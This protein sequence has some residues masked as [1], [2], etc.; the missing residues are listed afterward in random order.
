[1]AGVIEQINIVTTKNKSLGSG[2]GGDVYL[3][4]DGEFA[5]K[6]I[7]TEQEA[8]TGFVSFIKKNK[9]EEGDDLSEFHDTGVNFVREF[10]LPITLNHPNVMKQYGIFE[11]KGGDGKISFG[12]KLELADIGLDKILYSGTKERLS[13]EEKRSLSCQLFNAI[14]YLGQIG[15]V[16]RDIKPSNMMITKT[17]VLKIS[18]FGALCPSYEFGER[19]YY[20]NNDGGT[21]NYKPPEF[22][23]G[24]NN[25][26]Y[27]NGFDIWSAGVT[28]IEIYTSFPR[29]SN[30]GFIDNGGVAS[31]QARK[32]LEQVM[33]CFP[34]AERQ[35][36]YGANEGP[37]DFPWF[38]N[39]RAKIAY[40]GG[41]NLEDRF[42]QLML[43]NWGGDYDE[44][45][46]D[47][48]VNKV[49]KFEAVERTSEYFDHEFMN[50]YRNR[51]SDAEV[52]VNIN[53]TWDVIDLM[54]IPLK[55]H[56]DNDAYDSDD[57]D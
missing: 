1:M 2:A 56:S 43:N 40:L 55:Q 18:D 29:F 15:L 9:L 45:M 4:E 16:H 46:A 31:K 3:S 32:V 48:L 33:T 53:K 38:K 50:G 44:T 28:M 47:F 11:S 5:L 13:L 6:V 23:I 25:Y 42:R 39:N 51:K 54:K 19:N 14:Y 37:G 36:D 30:P 41:E 7:T 34:V 17:G 10:K 20:Y 22:L 52:G 8:G 49:L 35:V 26:E 24:V 27:N 12:V 57:L 21:E